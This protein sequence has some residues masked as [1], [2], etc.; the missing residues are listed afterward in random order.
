MIKE[1]YKKWQVWLGVAVALLLILGCVLGFSAASAANHRKA[2]IE[3][4]IALQEELNSKW[5]S[6]GAISYIDSDGA[7]EIVREH[8]GDSLTIDG[9]TGITEDQITA[10]TLAFETNSPVIVYDYLEDGHLFGLQVGYPDQES[11]ATYYDGNSKVAELVEKRI[12][13]ADTFAQTSF[14]AI[15]QSRCTELSESLSADSETQ[16]IDEA[17][18]K[19]EDGKVWIIAK[20]KPGYGMHTNRTESAYEA[21]KDY[22]EECAEWDT[23]L[24]RVPVGY[25]FLTS[26]GQ[27]DLEASSPIA[28]Y[29]AS[30][31]SYDQEGA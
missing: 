2:A 13:E 24:L 9:I 31:R 21:V 4:Y 25:R 14:D 26:D 11:R 20:Q 10:D 8:K 1:W 30:P 15:L 6:E 7:I 27:I 5:F 12:N 19:I 22:W 18:Y 3:D 17:Y 28:S 29:Y 23:R 16:W